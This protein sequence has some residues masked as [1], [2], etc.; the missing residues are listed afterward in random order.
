[1]KKRAQEAAR[2]K[3]EFLAVTS[4]ELTVTYNGVIGLPADAEKRIYTN[5][6]RSPEGHRTF[7]K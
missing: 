3:S 7:G 5:A 4:H 2:I 6:A 1:M